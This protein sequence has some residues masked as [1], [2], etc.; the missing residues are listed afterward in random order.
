[1][2]ELSCP[3]CDESREAGYAFCMRCG[4]PLRDC[5]KCEA[6]RAN[7]SR[8]CPRCGRRL[9]EDPRSDPYRWLFWAAVASS[10]LLAVLLSVELIAMLTGTVETWDWCSDGALNV[11]VLIPTL[12]VAGVLEGLSLQIYWIFLV[13]AI[14]AS[15][16]LVFRQSAGAFISKDRTAGR[17]EKTPLF[18]LGLLFSADLLLNLIVGL[19]NLG[20]S[21]IPTDLPLGPVPDAFLSFAN[22]AVWEEVISRVVYIGIP[23]A[24][25]ALVRRRRDAPLFLLGGFG[26][27]R[28]SLVLIVV[29][30][31]VFGFAHESGWGLWKVLPTF[32]S[33]LVMGYLYVRFGIH[34]SIAFHFGVD[35]LAVLMD[36]P[37]LM[38][39]SCMALAFMALGAPCLAEVARRGY[40]SRKRLKDVPNL[41]PP[42]QESIFR[43]RD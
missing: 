7:G 14:A 38:A 20:G 34:V 9:V 5:P 31:L 22:A 23:M 27:S 42:A 30:A 15:V 33:G 3:E 39:V 25:V 13:V 41:E 2:S 19:F 6:A 40:A 24:L 1:M 11:L 36:G 21:E 8:F 10:L 18:W 43:R 16:L 29:S 32:I 26:I 4:E 28:L 37:M 12:E 35:Y 17:I